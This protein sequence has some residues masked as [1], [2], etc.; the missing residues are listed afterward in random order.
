[1]SRTI[2]ILSFQNFYNVL[3]TCSAGR[4]NFFDTL[5]RGVPYG[6]HLCFLILSIE[7]MFDI[8][9]LFPI[10]RTHEEVKRVEQTFGSFLREK[11]I[12]RGLTLRGMAAK[13]DLSPVYM[14][15][16]ENDRRAAP[17]QEYLERMAMLLQLDKPEREW[18]LDLAAK[19]KQNR[20]SA[21]LPD[22]IMDREIV[23]AALRTAR[24]ADATDQEWQD[25]IDRINRR[26][27]SSGEDSDTKA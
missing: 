6:G 3:K 7:Q 24:E 4:K 19:S 1:M 17:S 11:R 12:A 21:D 22:Y 15:N 9:A 18:L 8:L 25:F 5:S 2:E 27:R 20:V 14:S 13:L 26:M 16:I 23:R 10:E